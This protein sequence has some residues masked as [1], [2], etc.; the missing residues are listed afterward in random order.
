MLSAWEYILLKE[1]NSLLRKIQKSHLKKSSGFQSWN[2]LQN[3]WKESHEPLC[4][5]H[6]FQQN[7]VAYIGTYICNYKITTEKWR[8]LATFIAPSWQWL[9]SSE[10]NNISNQE[11]LK[12]TSIKFNFF[13]K[14]CKNFKQ[15]SYFLSKEY[16]FDTFNHDNRIECLFSWR[17]HRL[18]VIR[19]SRKGLKQKFTYHNKFL[20]Q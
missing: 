1:I 17:F 14:I 16:S 7:W 11:F 6:Q 20:F 12:F 18:A 15:H 9:S 10:L 19:Y 8:F 4:Y 13:T 2:I 3:H 5:S